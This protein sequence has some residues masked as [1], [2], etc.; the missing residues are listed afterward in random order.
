ME[1]F[2]E[3]AAR[4]S[5]LYGSR[6]KWRMSVSEMKWTSAAT[7]DERKRRTTESIRGLLVRRMS[8]IRNERANKL[9][10]DPNEDL[11]KTWR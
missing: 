2:Y 8:E 6:L 9:A 11:P 3:C 1:K 10:P 7:T 4:P 5:V